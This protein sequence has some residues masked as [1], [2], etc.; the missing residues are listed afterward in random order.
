LTGEEMKFLQVF[1]AGTKSL[2]LGKVLVEDIA[3]VILLME[4][5]LKK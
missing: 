3:T 4:R 5:S 2:R 1:L